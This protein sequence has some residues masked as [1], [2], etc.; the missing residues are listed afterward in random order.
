[1]ISSSQR[2]RKSS[3]FHA[4][5]REPNFHQL[6]PDGPL[7]PLYRGSP[8]GGVTRVTR[9]AQISYSLVEHFEQ[10]LRDRRHRLWPAF[11]MA[12]HPQERVVL[13]N[14]SGQ[15]RLLLRDVLRSEAVC[16]VD[17]LRGLL[18][19]RD[20]RLVEM[21]TQ[22]KRSHG[23]PCHS[24]APSLGGGS[25]RLGANLDPHSR[26]LASPLHRCGASVLGLEHHR[27]QP[28]R[29]VDD[30][31]EVLGELA[32]LDRRRLTGHWRV[33]GEGPVRDGGV[34]CGVSDSGNV[35]AGGVVARF[36]S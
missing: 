9:R 10:P 13:A 28:A 25:D 7:A 32:A 23:T 30:G 12:D 27:A 15:R 4:L 6:E 36:C 26:I 19:A 16:R 20:L 14:R 17:Y 18:R 29:P 11:G 34:V 3:C 35:R 21:V 31:A 2:E 5:S 8:S 22:Q 24:D 33:S 1:M